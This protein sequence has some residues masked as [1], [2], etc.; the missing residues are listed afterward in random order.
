MGALYH[1][2]IKVAKDPLILVLN[3]CIFRKFTP[4][5]LIFTHVDRSIGCVSTQKLKTRY[6]FLKKWRNLRLFQNYYTSIK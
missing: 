4:V 3:Q 6:D 2:V 1:H 5:A